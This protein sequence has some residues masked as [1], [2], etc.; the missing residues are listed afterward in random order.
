M[1]PEETKLL[2][3]LVEKWRVRPKRMTRFDVIA[4]MTRLKC[5][6]ELAAVLKAARRQPAE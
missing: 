6:D 3:E 5:A 2:K 4:T 1:T